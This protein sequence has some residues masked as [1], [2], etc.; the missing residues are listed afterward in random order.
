MARGQDRRKTRPSRLK[1]APT[2]SISYMQKQGILA[3]MDCTLF[4]NGR[5]IGTETWAGLG[6]RVRM[7]LLVCLKKALH[8]EQDDVR[9]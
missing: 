3:G 1:A 7:T 4:G 8:L 5:K 6:D 2:E 9:R